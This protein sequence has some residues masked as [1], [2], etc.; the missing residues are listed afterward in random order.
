LFAAIGSA[1]DQESDAQQL[2]TVITLPII[3][4]ILFIQYILSNPD[5]TL[6][7]VLSLIPFFSPILMMVRIATTNVPIWQVIASVLLI[8]VT[9]WGCLVM[10]SKIYRIGILMYGKKPTFKDLFKW[11][12]MS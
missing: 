1:V 4:P 9:F 3:I 7:V 12:R 10:A 5:G 11:L 2:Q 6:S 8:L